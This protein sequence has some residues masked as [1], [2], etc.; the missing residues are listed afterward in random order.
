RVLLALRCRYAAHA[1][2]TVDYFDQVTSSNDHL[3]SAATTG[4]SVSSTAPGPSSRRST[5][6]TE[7]P[8]WSRRRPSRGSCGCRGA[9]GARRG[10]GG[11]SSPTAGPSARRRAPP[12]RGA[13]FT[14]AGDDGIHLEAT[15]VALSRGT[16]AN[17]LYYWAKGRPDE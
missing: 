12:T 13:S 11:W 7:T 2:P 14:L 8:F 5:A 1:L 9:S 6:T 16:E 10:G 17:F 15:H 3:T 4:G